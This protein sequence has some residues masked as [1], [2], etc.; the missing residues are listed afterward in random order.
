[1]SST[2]S[3]SLINYYGSK[4]KVEREKA[5]MGSEL[6]LCVSESRDTLTSES[7]LRP[8]RGGSDHNFRWRQIFRKLPG[9]RHQAFIRARR[10]RIMSKYFKIWNIYTREKMFH[11]RSNKTKLAILNLKEHMGVH[12]YPTESEVI[13]SSYGLD[14]WANE[15]PHHTIIPSVRYEPY[16]L[17]FQASLNKYM[18]YYTNNLQSV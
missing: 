11:T 9:R 15:G 2:H 12:Y 8:Y 1:M 6:H 7:T 16:N 17:S 13:N 18:N 14:G 3:T 10:K 4:A 5:S